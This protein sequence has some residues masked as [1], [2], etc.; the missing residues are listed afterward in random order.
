MELR[1]GVVLSL[2]PEKSAVRSTSHS[3]PTS[4]A[5]WVSGKQAINTMASARKANASPNENNAGGKIVF[6]LDE[7]YLS[8]VAYKETPHSFG[9]RARLPLNCVCVYG[10]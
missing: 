4:K 7:E 6:V 9:S 3:G 10:E 8:A 1:V 5:A 2:N